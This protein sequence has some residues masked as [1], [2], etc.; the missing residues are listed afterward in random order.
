MYYKQ[1]YIESIESLNS[2]INGLTNEES[3][4]RLDKVG[5]NELKEGNKVSTWKLFL[6]NFKDPLVI[7]L[8]IAAIVQIFLGELVECIIIFI[9]I[10]LNAILGVTLT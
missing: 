6:D 3:K 7:I 9:V 5:Y 10:I 1:K 4:R 2:N 8:L